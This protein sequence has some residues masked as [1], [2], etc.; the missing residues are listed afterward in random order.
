LCDAGDFRLKKVG[1]QAL[2]NKAARRRRFTP[3]WLRLRDGGR[4]DQRREIDWQRR[5]SSFTTL[6]KRYSTLRVETGIDGENTAECSDRLW[7]AEDPDCRLA[8]SS[9][10]LEALST[11]GSGGRKLIK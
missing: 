3:K 10:L 1:Y 2:E 4:S 8:Y 11:K 7:F 5:C 6:V 9:P